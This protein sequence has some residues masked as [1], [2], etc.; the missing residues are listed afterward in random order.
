[1]LTAAIIIGILGFVG[2]V[3]VED[4]KPV[5]VNREPVQW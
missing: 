5:Q 1:M 2:S 3:S 4:A